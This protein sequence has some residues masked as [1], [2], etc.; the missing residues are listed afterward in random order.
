MSR[1]RRF[2]DESWSELKKVTWPTREQ[3]RNLTVLVFVISAAVGAYI[4]VFDVIF[5]MIVARIETL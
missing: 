3:T 1:I 5:T 4:A 2:I